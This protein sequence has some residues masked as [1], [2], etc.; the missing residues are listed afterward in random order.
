M[1]AWKHVINF[2]TRFA[3]HQTAAKQTC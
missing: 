3:V 1:Q 2:Y